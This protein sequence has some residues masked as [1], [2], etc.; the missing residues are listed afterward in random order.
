MSAALELARITCTFISRHDRSQRYTAVEETSL[1]VAPGEFVSVVGPTGC[2]KSTLLNL[3]AGLLAPSSGS[4]RVFGEPL[5]GINGRAGYLFQS[6]A[7]MPW[8][9]ALQNVIA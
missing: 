9:N 2:G 6:E 1:A 3:A 4:V 8:R 7:L 5:R